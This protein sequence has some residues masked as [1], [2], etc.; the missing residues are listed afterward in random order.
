MSTNGIIAA[1][2]LVVCA[3][4]LIALISAARRNPTRDKD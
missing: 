2:W 3:A 4:Y 1:F